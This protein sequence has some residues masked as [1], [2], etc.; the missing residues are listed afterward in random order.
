MILIQFNKYNFVYFF[1]KVSRYDDIV[2]IVYNRIDNPSP[3]YEVG[4]KVMALNKHEDWTGVMMGCDGRAALPEDPALVALP[5]R[6]IT[7]LKELCL[8]WGFVCVA[9][10]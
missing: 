7:A 4:T 10:L 9:N 6:S 5:R 1:Q 2:D 3:S 8:L